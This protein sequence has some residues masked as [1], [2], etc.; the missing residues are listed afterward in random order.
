MSRSA[1]FSFLAKHSVQL[2]RLGALGE[3]FFADDANTA[4]L[5]MRQFAELLAQLTAAKLGMWTSPEAAARIL[6]RML[7]SRPR[8]GVWRDWIGCSKGG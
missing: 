5:K 4:I 2:E 3:R 8:T 6:S 1:N 7:F